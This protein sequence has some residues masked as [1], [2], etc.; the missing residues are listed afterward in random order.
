MQ[1]EYLKV[2][3]MTCGGCINT[4]TKALKAVSGVSEVN[5][6]LAEGEA[7]VQFDEARSSPDQLKAAIEEAGY[8][9]DGSSAARKHQSKGGCCG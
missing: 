2:T 3:G 7:T 8:G 4:V 1:T 5:V 6:S 9:I